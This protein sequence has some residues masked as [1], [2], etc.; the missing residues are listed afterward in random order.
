LSRLLDTNVAIHL[1]DGD[2]KSLSRFEALDERPFLSVLSVVELESGIHAKPELSG[3]RR[4]AVDAL[5]AQ[6]TTI[7]FDRNMAAA[8][9]QI[10]ANT[11]FSRRKIIDRMIAATALQH[12]LILITCNP[13]D[14][15]DVPGLDLEVWWAR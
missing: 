1:R 6:L 8:Y 15:E 2:E 4:L 13:T 12:D 9:G 3:T 14:F 11:G 5:L 10:V 7:D